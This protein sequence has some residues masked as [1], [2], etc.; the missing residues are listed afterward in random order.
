MRRR[1]FIAIAAALTAA[2]GFA[3]AQEDAQQPAL[4]PID[5]ANALERTF[6]AALNNEA[7]RPAFRRQLLES[8]VALAL[9]STAAD[10]PPRL[11]EFRPG[12]RTGFI[13]TSATRMNG[14]AGA[15]APRAML[16]GRAALQ[17]LRGNYAIVNYGLAPMLTL[18]PEDIVRMLET[19]VA[20]G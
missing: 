7:L 3:F 16:S 13:F 17:R 1:K 5:P 14:V 20:P 11:A 12:Q 4:Q 6:V 9:A 15:A 10:A 18:E 8:Q 19:P 2:P